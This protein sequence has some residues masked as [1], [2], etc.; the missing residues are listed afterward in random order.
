MRAPNDTRRHRNDTCD[1]TSCVAGLRSRCPKGRGSSDLPSRTEGLGSGCCAGRKEACWRGTFRVTGP[2]TLQAY[3]YGCTITYRSSIPGRTLILD[4]I[5]E[6][7][8][9]AECGPGDL[10]AQTAIF[11]SAP[12]IRER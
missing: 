5:G 3:G 10:V 7:G 1:E 2:D 8:E 4:V 11:D 12:F 6:T 9:A